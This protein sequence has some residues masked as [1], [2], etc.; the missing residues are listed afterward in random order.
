[1]KQ[2]GQRTVHHALGFPR[3]PPS[4]EFSDLFPLIVPPFLSL[5]LPTLPSQ[6]L[7]MGSEGR[8]PA[9]CGIWKWGVVT[10]VP[11]L[12]WHTMVHLVAIQWS[13]SL[14]LPQS[15]YLVHHHPQ[16]LGTGDRC[17]PW[18]GAGGLWE[19]VMPGST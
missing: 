12:G 11:A 14:S 3:L 17:L 13:K 9:P 4:P 8:P 2:M 10:A 5:P 7:S 6:E 15:R 18:V 19:G 1:M 16:S